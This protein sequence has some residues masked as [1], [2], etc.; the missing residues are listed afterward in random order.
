MNYLKKKK[1][2]EYL[3]IFFPFSLVT[4]PL[5]PE[6]I[7]LISIILFFILIYETNN[8][9]FLI[10][11]F[12][13]IFLIFY[14]LI[15]I[16]SFFAD[17]SLFSL[18]NTLF[19]FRFL[20][21]A[22]I[23]KYLILNNAKFINYLIISFTIMLSI[24]SIDTIIEYVIGS[25]WLFDKTIYSENDNHRISGLFD[26][27]YI[28]GGF[29]LAFF[30]STLLL[31]NDH[32]KSD[33]KNKIFFIIILFIV[34]TTSIVL[35]GERAS[36]AKMVLLFISI[37]FF[38]RIFGK[39]RGKLITIILMIFFIS[40]FIIS[41][42]KLNERLIYHTVDLILQNKEDHKKIDRNLS[43]YEYFKSADLENLN[44]TYYSD[45]HSDHAKISINMFKDKFIFGHGVKMF[46]F[47]CSKNEYYI[48]DRACS[49]HSHGIFFSFI[50]ELGIIGLI[51][52]I[53]IYYYL[54]K[55]TIKTNETTEKVILLTILIYLFPFVPSGYFFNNFF[56]LV[57]YFLVGIYLGKK[58]IN[59]H[60]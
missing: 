45:E 1:I 38:T 49:T 28:I 29:I 7:L 18:K 59:L 10:N 24:I 12:S 5:I 44:F 33:N 58:K 17:E 27:E 4:G 54:I 55:R 2:L 11:D 31:I 30:P 57:L 16:R 25:H 34:F 52:L 35:S 13:K 14:L 50:S 15:V 6:L 47:S 40:I 21:F 22:L 36:L 46:R 8:F 42:P 41:Q 43:I 19:Y 20:I 9:N 32:L 60:N 51:F 39:L 37:I 26:E 53:M 56:S 23:I 48:N 3:I